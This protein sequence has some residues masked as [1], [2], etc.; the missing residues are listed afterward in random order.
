MGK[1]YSKPVDDVDKDGNTAVLKG[2]LG[3]ESDPSQAIT[4]K[5]QTSTEDQRREIQE[6]LNYWDNH[7]EPDLRDIVQIAVYMRPENLRAW[8]NTRLMQEYGVVDFVERRTY[9]HAV[10][11]GRE[12]IS[13]QVGS[14]HSLFER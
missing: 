4:L 6:E 9:M 8:L 1:E 11:K 10:K 13:V 7:I 3:S 12:L 14:A 2:P 5:L